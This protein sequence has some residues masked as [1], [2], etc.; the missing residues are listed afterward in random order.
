MLSIFSVF[1]SANDGFTDR[2]LFNTNEP[3]SFRTRAWSNQT[4]PIS[5]LGDN[6][7]THHSE[8]RMPSEHANSLELP[9]TRILIQCTKPADVCAP[10][11]YEIAKAFFTP[12]SRTTRASIAR[13]NTPCTRSLPHQI[14]IRDN[15]GKPAKF[16]QTLPQLPNSISELICPHCYAQF[17]RTASG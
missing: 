14:T 8:T 4:L 10:S 15:R 1:K 6:M 3:I 13:P 5:K 16:W 12:T 17:L 9:Q 7:N 11:P 2:K